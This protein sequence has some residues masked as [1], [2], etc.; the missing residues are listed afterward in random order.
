MNILS[1]PTQKR[2]H[3]LK[4]KDIIRI[5][6]SSNYSKI[7]F[8]GGY[9]ITVAKI[10]HWFEDTLPPEMFSRVH[11]RHLVNRLFM[12]EI[13]GKGSSTLLLSNGERIA[14]SRRKKLVQLPQ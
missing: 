1:I 8:V 5:E 4:V 14:M 12:N 10:L 11:R 2:L 9:P 6:A 7:Y 13:N 3:Q